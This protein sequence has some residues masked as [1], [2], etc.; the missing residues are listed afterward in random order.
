MKGINRHLIKGFSLGIIS[1]LLLLALMGAVRSTKVTDEAIAVIPTQTRGDVA[2]ARNG[3]YRISACS[4]L[5]GSG[6]RGGYGVFVIDTTTGVT[7]AAYVSFIDNRGRTVSVNQLGKP[8][9]M[10]KTGTR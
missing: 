4:F 7:K 3:R 9:S 8:F 1:S 5:P 10:I 2:L 6:K